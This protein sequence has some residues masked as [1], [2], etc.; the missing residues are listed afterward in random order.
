MAKRLNFHPQDDEL[1]QVEQALRQD[2]RVN[3]TRCA[4]GPLS[5]AS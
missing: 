1:A 4:S 3:S 5:S 2:K